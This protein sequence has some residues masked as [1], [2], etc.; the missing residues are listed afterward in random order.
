[1]LK[2]QAVEHA[3]D[4]QSND[5]IWNP[6]RFPPPNKVAQPPWRDI[7]LRLVQVSINRE[8]YTN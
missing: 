7:G 1:M 5:A 4:N 3:H 8:L 2:K 6:H